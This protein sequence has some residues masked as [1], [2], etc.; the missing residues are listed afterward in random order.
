MIATSFPTQVW[1]LHDRIEK[2]ALTICNIRAARKVLPK[3]ARILKPG[4]LTLAVHGADEAWTWQQ[5]VAAFTGSARCC[6]LST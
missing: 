1:T 4:Q 3:R 6:L 5:R 2:P